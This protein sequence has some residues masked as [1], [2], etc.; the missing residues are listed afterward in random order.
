MVWDGKHLVRQANTGQY[1]S[2]VASGRAEG[3]CALELAL[4]ALDLI[5]ALP[6]T[7]CKGP[8]LRRAAVLCRAARDELAAEVRCE[9][10]EFG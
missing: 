8:P 2:V 6:M 5:G 10:R 3:R 7:A 1:L 9:L 4:W